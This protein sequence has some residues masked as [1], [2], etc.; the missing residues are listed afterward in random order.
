M[1]RQ[2]V[3]EVTTAVSDAQKML[4]M[5]LTAAA[6]RCRD[7]HLG[8][9]RM[10][11]IGLAKARH[12]AKEVIGDYNQ[13]LHHSRITISPAVL[14]KLIGLDTPEE[15]SSQQDDFQP[16]P[17]SQWGP[18]AL[19]AEK[20]KEAV[21]VARANL[22]KSTNASAAQLK[23]CL[24]DA[25]REYVAQVKLVMTK[26]GSEW[27]SSFEKAKRSICDTIKD[28]GTCKL[29]AP[30]VTVSK[31][32]NICVAELHNSKAH[33]QGQDSKTKEQQ[34]TAEEKAQPQLALP[35]SRSDSIVDE[36]TSPSVVDQASRLRKAIAAAKAAPTSE[37]ALRDLAAALEAAQEEAP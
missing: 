30:S 10:A 29:D 8:A 5:Q 27:A 3:H 14:M 17:W 6:T 9:L 16:L 22:V 23:H 11:K 24:C 12:K 19:A 7:R 32:S 21:A 37:S 18:K 1:A 13:F 34:R 36:S 28:G 31:E 2:L 20:S 4:D 15:T 25:Q 35:L 33:F 26:R